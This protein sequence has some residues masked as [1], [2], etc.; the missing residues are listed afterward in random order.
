[1][2]RLPA[3]GRSNLLELPLLGSILRRRRGRLLPQ[4]VLLL[5]AILVIYDGL[6]G[7]QVAPENLATVVVWLHYRGL[8][9]L[10][11][12][13]AGNLFCMS[14]P[15]AL[16]RTAAHRLSRQG[17][18]WPRLLRNKW[19]AI[20]VFFLFLFAYEWFDLWASPWLTAWV[21]VA[22]FAGAFTLE[23][24]FEDSPFCK[25][26]CPLGTFNFAGSTISPLQITV[27]DR[28]LCR[29]CPGKEC[30]NGDKGILGC[31]T[32]LFP[33]K[34]TS[35]IDCVFCLDC[36]RACPYGNV[37]LARRS[38]L[39]ELSRWD[40]W[41]HRWDWSMLALVFAFSALGNAFG[42]VPPFYELEGEIATLLRTER[43]GLVLFLIFGVV[44]LLFPAGLGLGAAWLSGRLSAK[45]EPLRHTFSRYA[46]AVIPLG[47]AVWLA[48]YG[49]HFA[50]GAL[51]LIPVTQNFLLDHGIAFFGRPD[52]T[53]G[54]ILPRSWLLPL[55]IVI[56]LLG[57]AASLYLVDERADQA[58]SG[59]DPFPARL[60]W[61]LLFLTIALAAILL[62]TLPME[63]RGTNFMN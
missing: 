46:P 17:R 45:G 39:Q 43:S 6:T 31:G 55:E 32:M 35:N 30:V 60:P 40:A 19:V 16:P 4:L 47:F 14:C 8:V 13:L 9:V 41:P 51:S 10:A 54:A 2:S 7:P 34:L 57:L 26:V 58:E 33:P 61:I 63:M 22:Y 48:H 25:Y 5:A 52:W 29:N 50:T 59:P 56:T 38:P 37:A 3:V 44:D 15:F 49:F 23:A 24:L 12:L 53:A 36:A 28:D 42:M 11:L 62:F 18:R 1:M 27:H 20:L 21:V